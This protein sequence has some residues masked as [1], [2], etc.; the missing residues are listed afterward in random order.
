M[1]PLSFIHI[2]WLDFSQ[3][4]LQ[5][6][7]SLQYEGYR[8]LLGTKVSAIAQFIFF[9]QLTYANLENKSHYLHWEAI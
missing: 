4:S 9:K 3:I 6:P 1:G 8:F 5:N 2:D 7:S